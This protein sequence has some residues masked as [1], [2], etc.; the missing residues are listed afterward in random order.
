MQISLDGVFVLKMIQEGIF[1]W[2]C[3]QS[4]FFMRLVS[5]NN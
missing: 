2:K 3:E 4:S 1:D 5:H